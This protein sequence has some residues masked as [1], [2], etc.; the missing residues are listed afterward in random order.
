MEPSVW[1]EMLEPATR[2]L[3]AST[4]PPMLSRKGMPSV[5]TNCVPVNTPVMNGRCLLICAVGSVFCVHGCGTELELELD[6]ELVVE[7]RIVAGFPPS[8]A[9]FAGV[10]MLM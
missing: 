3:A 1:M 9:L 6:E 8:S 5:E 2:L 4:G 7:Q 10:P